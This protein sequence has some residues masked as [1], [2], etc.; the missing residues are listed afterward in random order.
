MCTMYVVVIIIVVFTMTIWT[1][2]RSLVFQ[3][4]RADTHTHK[5]LLDSTHADV[6]TLNYFSYEYRQQF[7][8][9]LI[10]VFEYEH[11]SMTIL[12]LGLYNLQYVKTTEFRNSKC[13]G[14][15]NL[16]SIM[17]KRIYYAVG[18][19]EIVIQSNDCSVFIYYLLYNSVNKM[20]CLCIVHLCI[21]LWNFKPTLS[22]YW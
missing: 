1:Q 14:N 12:I 6:T 19:S 13:I 21:I 16:I 7:F 22:P 15:T 4:L 8:N 9:I 10:T 20:W 17:A 18:Q 3:S 2:L 5:L 11:G